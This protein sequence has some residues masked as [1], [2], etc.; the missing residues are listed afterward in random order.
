[1]V[2]GPSNESCRARRER[3]NRGGAR[4]RWFQMSCNRSLTDDASQRVSTTATTLEV[5]RLLCLLGHPSRTATLRAAGRAMPRPQGK[6]DSSGNVC[7]FQKREAHDLVGTARCRKLFWMLEEVSFFSLVMQSNSDGWHRHLLSCSTTKE[8]PLAR[9][10]TP[11]SSPKPRPALVRHQSYCCR[12]CCSIQR[13]GQCDIVR[14]GSFLVIAFAA[15]QGR[16]GILVDQH[17]CFGQ[18]VMVAT[19]LEHFPVVITKEGCGESQGRN[20]GGM[21]KN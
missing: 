15:K 16:F 20:S 10:E 5:S 14:V 12:N 6:G 9:D 18:I 1:M 19:T 2:S 13:C 11:D 7:W 4:L 8:H 17:C 3:P 21:A